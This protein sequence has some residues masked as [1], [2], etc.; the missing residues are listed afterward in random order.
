ME[1]AE[2]K[3]E[4]SVYGNKNW[5]VIIYLHNGSKSVQWYKTER[6]AIYAA[7]RWNNSDHNKYTSHINER[8]V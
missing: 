7:D 5:K 6:D 4:K 8:T 2:I 1:A 3:K